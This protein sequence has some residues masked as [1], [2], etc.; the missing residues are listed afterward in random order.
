MKLESLDLA[1]GMMVV[2]LLVS[3][4]C[5]ALREAI[6]AMLKT[7]A[8][9]LERAIREMLD[10]KD[11][12]GL[13]ESLFDHPQL[14]GLFLGKYQPKPAHKKLWVLANGRGLP[15]YIPASSFAKALLDITAHGA[16][17]GEQA[18]QPSGATV[19]IES[20]RARLIDLQSPMSE[21]VRRVLLHALD[22][23]RG[24]PEA[25]K[26]NVEDWFND[27]MDRVS[28]WYKRSTQWIVFVIALVVT[29]TGNVDS[30]GIAKHLY[31][32]EVARN[33][34]VASAQTIVAESKA[35]AAE[36]AREV[37]EQLEL[38]V[39]WSRTTLP[40]GAEWFNR[41]LGWFLTAFAA[42]LG[43]P[44]WFDVLN[45]VMVIC[46]TVKP[47]E[48]SPDEFAE[49]RQ[50]PPAPIIQAPA[51]AAAP[52][53]TVAT[54]SP[55]VANAT[56]AAAAAAAAQDE[57]DCCGGALEEPTEDEQLPGASGG[58]QT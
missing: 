42:T 34:A 8:A 56:A 24:D 30:I 57:L 39:G 41:V 20:L 3:T 16:L 31:R 53:S 15:S 22:T 52:A 13:S 28:G 32:D 27:S 55:A 10:D 36:K 25:A 49:D 54:P 23:A 7:R 12:T 38:P 58:V 1:I 40:Q 29:V 4:L 26:R 18:T 9:Y 47:H 2:F 48:K 19:T 43:A 50:A 5:S 17:T 45:R 46:S 33:A 35:P 6:E 21:R 11:G 14:S 37:L 51:G 44:F